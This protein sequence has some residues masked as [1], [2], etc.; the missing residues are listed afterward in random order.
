[1]STSRAL[2]RDPNTGQASLVGAVR[3]FSIT[4]TSASYPGDEDCIIA[5]DTSTGSQ[6]HT[7]PSP[8]GRAGRQYLV[9]ETKPTIN[10]TITLVRAGSEKINGV[11]AN[12]LLPGSGASST[13]YGRWH[14]WTDG[15]DWYVSV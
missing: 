12:L 4:T 7:L 13:S 6:S 14:V 1:M 8:S 11:A 3:V 15:T 5:A 10:N 9:C 2:F